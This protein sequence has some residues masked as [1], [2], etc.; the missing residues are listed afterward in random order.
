MWLESCWLSLF[1]TYSSCTSVLF[2]SF[3]SLLNT[4]LFCS[5][6]C[7]NDDAIH[8]DTDAIIARE[9]SLTKSIDRKFNF[10]GG[11]LRKLKVSE[12]D[13]ERQFLARAE[14][15]NRDLRP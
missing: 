7:P 3:S 8:T 14:E 10:K 5:I 11:F 2:L 4:L 1:V 13:A 9:K 12:S 15:I 6:N